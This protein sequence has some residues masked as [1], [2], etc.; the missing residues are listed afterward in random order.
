MHAREGPQRPGFRGSGGVSHGLGGIRGCRHPATWGNAAGDPRRRVTR[1]GESSQTANYGLSR[2][3]PC[4]RRGAGRPPKG[5]Q[6]TAAP[7][8]LA[9]RSPPPAT[10]EPPQAPRSTGAAPRTRAAAR[11][12]PNPSAA[13]RR[14]PSLC[15]RLAS[16]PRCGA[17]PR[18]S[19]FPWGKI[20][21]ATKR[22]S[23]WTS[24]TD[25]SMSKIETL[26]EALILGKRSLR[27]FT[28]LRALLERMRA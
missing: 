16:A 17:K 28:R 6:R 20:R 4:M 26:G 5:P 25:S 1:G 27:A 24:R 3:L 22:L 11:R 14:T 19:A 23:F 2:G 8:A 10:R 7:P 15:C 13:A 18:R 12:A 21:K 9:A